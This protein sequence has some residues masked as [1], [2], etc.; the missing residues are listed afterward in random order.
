MGYDD[1][2]ALLASLDRN[3]IQKIDLATTSFE[4][5]SVQR[6]RTLTG[7]YVEHDNRYTWPSLADVSAIADT[8]VRMNDTRKPAIKAW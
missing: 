8:V 3:F 1:Y 5:V 2:D 7:C 4:T 6:D